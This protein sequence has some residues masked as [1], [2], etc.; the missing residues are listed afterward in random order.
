MGRCLSSSMD[1][2]IER[3]P[4][5]RKAEVFQLLRDVFYEDTR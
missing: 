2:M 5:E 4:D 3:L 1:I